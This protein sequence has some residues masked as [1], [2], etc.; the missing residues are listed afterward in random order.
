MVQKK[1][2][3]AEIHSVLFQIKIFNSNE[4]TRPL[5]IAYLF[6]SPWNRP[7]NNE[8]SINTE[9]NFTKSGFIIRQI[10]FYLKITNN[11]TTQTKIIL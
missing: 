3:Y 1:T 10:Y 4:R 6:P 5:L 2:E 11:E 8:V 9:I 7:S